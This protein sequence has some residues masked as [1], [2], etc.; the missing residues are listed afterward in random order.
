MCG[1]HWLCREQVDD[2]CLSIIAF[3]AGSEL[4]VGDLRRIQK[5]VLAV[6]RER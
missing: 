5:Q 4:H 6:D 1:A 3:S 2:A